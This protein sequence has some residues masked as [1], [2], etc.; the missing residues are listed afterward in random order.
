MV[1]ITLGV[2]L[3]MA[4][5]A[6]AAATRDRSD[7][8]PFQIKQVT[9]LMDCMKTLLA[10]AILFLATAPCGAQSVGAKSSAPLGQSFH[11]GG[12]GRVLPNQW[13]L[14]GV[15][16]QNPTE[17][18]VDVVSVMHFADNP[19]QQYARRLWLPAKSRRSASFPILAPANLPR[20]KEFV[21]IRTQLLN[22]TGS[23]EV[24]VKNSSG[25][26]LGDAILPIGFER[27]VTGLIDDGENEMCSDTV[28]AMRLVR[29][30]TRRVAALS[31]NFLPST[32]EGLQGLDQLVLCSNRIA[33]DSAG[34]S[35]VREWVHSG[36]R[37]WIMLDRVNA[38]TVS[39]LLG[40]GLTFQEVD[41]ARLTKFTV[42]SYWPGVVSETGHELEFVEP[43]EFARVVAPHGEIMHKIDGWPA[44]FFLNVG[45]G[46]VLCTTLAARA[47]IRP[48]LPSDPKVTD[49]LRDSRYLANECLTE[50]AFEFM[51]RPREQPALESKAFQEFVSEQIGYRIVSRGLVLL[52]LGAFCTGVIGLGAWL[53]YRGMLVHLGWLGP[54]TAI[55][56]AT[57]L[58]TVGY[59]M[60]SSVPPT[61]AVAQLAEISHDADDL[62]VTG[63]MALYQQSAAATELGAENGGIFAPDM[64]GQEGKARRMV[65]TDQSTSHWESLVLPAGL[66]MAPFS[67]SGKLTAP[68]TAR[69]SFG[70]QGLVGSIESGPFKNIADGLIA[71]PGAPLMAV[72]LTADGK[73]TAGPGDVLA[74]AEFIGGTLLNDDRRRR[75]AIYRKLLEVPASDTAKDQEDRPPTL[76][77]APVRTY[78][79][80]PTL[81]VWADALDLQFQLPSEMQKVGSALLAIP[82]SFE[83]STPGSPVVI[84]APCLTFQSVGNSG[85]YTNAE[86]RW[87]GP[88]SNSSKTN[89]KFMVPP[90]AF[91]LKL[92]R[93]VLTIVINAPGRKLEVSA[94][95]A[96]NLIPLETYQSPVGT[97]RVEITKP[98]ALAFDASG[99]LLLNLEVGSAPGSN[100][101][102]YNAG[103]IRDDAIAAVWK[104]ERVQLEVAGEAQ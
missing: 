1:T 48:R 32:I 4:L 59:G 77:E 102:Q 42:N 87:L 23:T 8:C 10:G 85:A 54:L 14:V 50:L 83:H 61:V 37:L 15:D 58:V 35:A 74:S 80:Q 94:G 96:T 104:I 99:G 17:H 51:G 88:L 98:E 101:S 90:E 27:P 28:V 21:D 79:N 91:P 39:A 81:L 12:I 43:V 64:S 16:V 9:D 65:W 40:D 100:S 69:A 76:Q 56:A 22:R 45:R 71:M 72:Q 26:M 31:G 70:P 19:Y 53:A 44:S 57:V 3:G 67:Y 62:Q 68:I 52:V 78:P 36:G 60:R 30:V 46:R 33:N 38:D 2:S 49:V 75:R 95:P 93:A 20:G 84:P 66:R 89:L 18:P 29:N 55:G 73:F 47:W 92:N 97:L 5:R 11:N 82:L 63:L 6:G 41:R 103:G 24:F 25:Q 34:L 86:K 13:G 7:D